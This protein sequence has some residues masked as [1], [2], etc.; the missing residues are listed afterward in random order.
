MENQGCC[1]TGSIVVGRDEWS[2]EV[3]FGEE[4]DSFLSGRFK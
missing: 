1:I 3:V 4:C 2:I